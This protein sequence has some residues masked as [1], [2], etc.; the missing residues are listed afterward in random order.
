MPGVTGT[1][2][3]TLLANLV[4]ADARAGRGAV[5]LD[6]KGDMITDLLDRLPASAAGRLVLIDAAE[7][8]APAALNILDG[9]EPELAADQMVTIF[10]RIA[11][12]RRQLSPA[13][14]TTFGD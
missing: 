3:T 10:R 1:G 8:E 13:A 9:A 14:A 7:T 2:K 6:P 4:L 5:V 11:R 12:L